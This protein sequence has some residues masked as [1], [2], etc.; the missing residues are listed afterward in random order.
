M[1]YYPANSSS[2]PPSERI[3]F[4]LIDAQACVG[5]AF[6]EVADSSPAS[7]V[8]LDM[9]SGRFPAEGFGRAAYIRLGSRS[10]LLFRRVRRSSTALSRSGG[11]CFSIRTALTGA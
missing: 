9:G 4:D 7:W 3:P 6:G 1:G 5:Q 2:G 11:T 8:N 10:Y